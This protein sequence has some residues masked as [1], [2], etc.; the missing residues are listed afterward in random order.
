MIPFVI[1]SFVM[2]T[3]SY[4]GRKIPPPLR[5]QGHKIMVAASAQGSHSGNN[6]REAVVDA[7]VTLCI[8]PLV[9]LPMSEERK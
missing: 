7:Q 5:N 9:R 6:E 2:M 1:N 3:C 4:R 8:Y